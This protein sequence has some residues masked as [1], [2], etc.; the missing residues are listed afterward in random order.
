MRL[1]WKF[2]DA[3]PEDPTSEALLAELEERYRFS[4]RPQPVFR[5]SSFYHAVP[6]KRSTALDML[7]FL[8]DHTGTVQQTTLERDVQMPESSMAA[9]VRSGPLPVLGWGVTKL[10][11][12]KA[13]S[14]NWQSHQIYLRDAASGGIDAL[15]A[16]KFVGG[17]G[18]GVR[19][20]DL[21]RGCET[22]HE[23]LKRPLDGL[24]V[25]ENS[26]GTQTMG[27]CCADAS[28]GVGVVGIVHRARVELAPV[29]RQ[30]GGLHG[31]SNVAVVLDRV[32][33]NLRAGDVI[34]LELEGHFDASLGPL[35]I[36]PTQSLPL[37][38]SPDVREAIDRAE[39]RGI[40]VVEPA[41]NGSHDLDR[42]GL[43]DEDRSSAI[44]VGA[45]HPLTHDHLALS[46]F[47]SRVDLQGW[48]TAVVTTGSDG[49]L[50]SHPDKR[51]RYTQAFNGTSS[52]SAIVAG[53]VA[54]LCG[55]SKANG[56]GPLSPVD[57]REL[58][59][60]T[61]TPQG[62]D[63][64]QHIGPLPN[65]RA[66]IDELERRVGKPLHRTGEA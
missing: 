14:Y 18:E 21:E 65:L 50:Q 42:F 29:P 61:G 57:M 41:G 34:L 30:E 12:K 44:M 27:V 6:V 43:G 53:A 10:K 8:L 25:P 32:A 55:I 63:R 4:L 45:G 60:T 33:R 35:G 66:A 39:E 20:V 52:A 17:R 16:W 26:H 3:P 11:S 19:L 1:V 51:R 23:D 13:K 48:G 31:Y 9:A 58:L 2:A 46:N 62:G 54:C 7:R 37:E 24:S 56:V 36:N 40:H 5:G 22:D 47:G 15:H 38:L 28:N 49:T 59:V 64:S